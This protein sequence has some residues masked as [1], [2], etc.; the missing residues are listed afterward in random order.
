M[1]TDSR[2]VFQT[3]SHCIPSRSGSSISELE[4]KRRIRDHC[5]DWPD[6][7]PSDMVR[8][9]FR[10]L[11]PGIEFS[12]FA[13][14]FEEATGYTY[15][16]ICQ[17]ASLAYADP[18]LQTVVDDLL[19]LPRTTMPEAIAAPIAGQAGNADFPRLLDIRYL[20]ADLVFSALNG[21]NPSLQRTCTVEEFEHLVGEI[22]RGIPPS[23][24]W[25]VCPPIPENTDMLA[26][27]YRGEFGGFSDDEYRYVNVLEDDSIGWIATYGVD[28]GLQA[29]EAFE[30]AF[31]PF[32]QTL[33]LSSF[34]Q[35]RLPLHPDPVYFEDSA[36]PRGGIVGSRFVKQYAALMGID[37]SRLAFTADGVRTL[38]LAD[39]ATSF[40]PI[41]A[42]ILPG[43]GLKDGLFIADE[44]LIEVNN[45]ARLC[46]SLPGPRGVILHGVEKGHVF[47]TFIYR[48]LTGAERV[49]VLHSGGSQPFPEGFVLA[50]G[51][52]SQTDRVVE[53]SYG[54]PAAG[55]GFQV[56][57]EGAEGSAM[58]ELAR[59]TGKPRTELDLLLV[60]HDNPSHILVGEC[61]FAWEYKGGYFRAG[62]R[63][64]EHAARAIR[65]SREI[66]TALGLPDKLP[67]V[68]VLFVSH[69]GRGLATPRPSLMITMTQALSG[70]FRHS[71]ETFLARQEKVT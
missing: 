40:V 4:L 56:A 50:R 54:P 44:S 61:K 2:R 10:V 39:L 13:V 46:Y 1:R 36:S 65:E 60:Q 6:S 38:R 29:K 68:S 19:L 58:S 7:V 48:L 53:Y 62:R 20:V 17:R 67:V 47:E 27:Y 41:F 49:V 5:R 33:G 37:P 57:I 43:D 24:R 16:R 35:Y 12:E 15:D 25:L 11:D 69:S 52:R 32:V 70:Q 64:V 9:C 66:R 30:E 55:T 8:D 21:S 22:A 71:A 18:V 14:V 59:S 3:L 28:E 45:P 51:P 31:R 42:Q 34:S 26:R 23:R 63:F